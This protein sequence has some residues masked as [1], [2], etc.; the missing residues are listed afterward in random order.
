MLLGKMKRRPRNDRPSYR[1]GWGRAS[2][3]TRNTPGV[4]VLWRRDWGDVIQEWETGNF[5]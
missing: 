3:A 5:I 4:C 2:R 1:S